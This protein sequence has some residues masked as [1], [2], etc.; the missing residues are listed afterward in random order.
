MSIAGGHGRRHR[1]AARPSRSPTSRPG[2]HV[3][4]VLTNLDGTIER[5]EKSLTDL[6]AGVDRLTTLDNRGRGGL[7]D[8]KALHRDLDITVAG[9]YGWPASVAQDT[10]SGS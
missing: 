6:R 9:C 2:G 1:P 10:S 3:P 4:A 8:L 7:A 5:A